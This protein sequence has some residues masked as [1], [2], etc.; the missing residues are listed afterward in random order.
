MVRALLSL[1][2]GGILDRVLSTVDR[3][4]AAETDREAL[5]ADIIREHYRSRADFMRAGGMWLML[6]FAAPLGVWWGG[7][8]LYSLLWCAGCAYPQQWTIAALPAPL[9]EWA[10]IIILSIFGVVGVTRFRR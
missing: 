8:C 5:K 1:L 9:D 10:A 3:K 6:L 2:S 4:I 7:V